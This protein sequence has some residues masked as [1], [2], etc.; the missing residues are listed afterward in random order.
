MVNL[1]FEIA[2]KELRSYFTGRMSMLRNLLMLAIFSIVPIMKIDATM[3]VSGYS[4]EITGQSLETYLLF[5]SMYAIVMGSISPSWPSPTRRRCGRSS[6][7][8]ASR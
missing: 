8:S 1:I 5:S 7:C 3:K 6:T 4:A 2:R